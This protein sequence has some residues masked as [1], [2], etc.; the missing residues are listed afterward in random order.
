MGVTISGMDEMMA[1]LDRL[2][3]AAQ[4]LDG[5]H[6]VSFGELFPQEFMSENTSC[7]TIDDFFAGCGH[8]IRSDDDIDAIPGFDEYVQRTTTFPSWEEM[9]G[10]ALDELVFREL[11]L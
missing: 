9:K 7:A 11:G 4:E 10:T 8:E 2:S 5:E 1:E 6:E 3:K